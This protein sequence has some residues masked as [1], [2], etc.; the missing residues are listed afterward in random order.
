MKKVAKSILVI[1]F[2]CILALGDLTT[3]YTNHVYA[4]AYDFDVLQANLISISASTKHI[5]G[6]TNETDS[7]FNLND[8]IEYYMSNWINDK[9]ISKDQFKQEEDIYSY[10]NEGIYC[11]NVI[12]NGIVLAENSIQINASIINSNNYTIIYSKHGDITINTDQLNYKGILYAPN[13]KV[14]I[15]CRECN[16]DGMIISSIIDINANS[17]NIS[18]NDETN[19]I[20]KKLCYVK[21]ALFAS[22]DSSYN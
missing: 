19:S 10:D 8:G 4:S 7:L 2:V 1:L 12:L 5:I 16:I 15:N 11:N 9:T 22:F 6:N 18:G 20:V 13:G 17:V 3:F 21:N 14:S